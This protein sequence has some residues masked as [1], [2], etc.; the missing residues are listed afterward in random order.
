MRQYKQLLLA[1]KAWSAEIIEESADF[2]QRQLVGQNPEF[3]WI[4]CSDSRVSPEQMTMTV[5]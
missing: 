2:F 1:N 4:G 3:L 5:V